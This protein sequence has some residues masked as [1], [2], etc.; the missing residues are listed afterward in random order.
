ME[1]ELVAGWWRAS[2]S[3]NSTHYTHIITRWLSDK[4]LAA[5]SA[6][7]FV[8]KKLFEGLVVL[9]DVDSAV[10]VLNSEYSV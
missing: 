6:F 9:V 4:I 10:S 5:I 1:N 7:E 8:Q 2:A 3:L